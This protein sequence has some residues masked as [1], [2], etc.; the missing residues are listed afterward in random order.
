MATNGPNELYQSILLDASCV[1]RI[2][3]A[4]NDCFPNLLVISVTKTFIVTGLQVLN[5]GSKR[6]C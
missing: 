5:C 6:Y 2:V 1:Q 4:L 3:Y